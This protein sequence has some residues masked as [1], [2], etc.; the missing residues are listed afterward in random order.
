[1][2]NQLPSRPSL[3]HLKKQAK[4]LIA[5]HK[6]ADAGVC[7]TLRHLREFAGEDDATILSAPLPRSKAQLALAL[8]YGFGGWNELREYVL[9]LTPWDSI[10]GKSESSFPDLIVGNDIR[11]STPGPAPD[12]FDAFTF[13]WLHPMLEHFETRIV[14]SVLLPSGREHIIFNDLLGSAGTS[15]RS[16][17]D[18]E[19]FSG[20]ARQFRGKPIVEIFRSLNGRIRFGTARNYRFVFYKQ[21]RAGQINWQR[22]YLEMEALIEPATV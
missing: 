22:P 2:T 5:G 6:R 13:F 3:E 10:E 14:W 12:D 16:D 18:A 21:D 11:F 4:D 15:T 20:D 1:M 19:H 7:T 8:S 9:K 17:Y